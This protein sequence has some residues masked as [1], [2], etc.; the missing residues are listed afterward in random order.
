[1]KEKGIAFFD[2]DGTITSKDTFID[3]IIFCR[4]RIFFYLGIIAL[5]PFILLKMFRLYANHRLKELFFRF[6]LAHHYSAQELEKLGQ[7]YSM[8]KLPY[9]IYSQALKKINWHKEN[10]HEVIILTA[11]SPLWLS[12]WCKQNGLKLIGTKFEIKN[13]KYTGK[14]LGR[15]CYGIQ[16]EE[17]VTDI[18]KQNSGVMTFGYGDTKADLLF[19]NKLNYRYYKPYWIKRFL[20][21]H[22]PK[23]EE[24][25]VLS[26]K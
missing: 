11:S 12:E 20:S 24:H 9:I 21:T 10:N 22:K 25:G 16:K 8:Q 14:I 5:S 17:I 7:S 1:M 18:L 6:Y 26:L 13:G 4:G 2:L 15:N 19:L 3:F 23:K